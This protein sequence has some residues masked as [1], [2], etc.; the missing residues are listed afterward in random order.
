ML[1]ITSLLLLCLGFNWT[2][3]GQN[4]QIVLT[5]PPSENAQ[6]KGPNDIIEFPEVDSQFKGGPKGLQSYISKNVHYPD[7]AV[8]ENITGKVYLSFV[9][10][11]NGK[12]SNVVVERSAHPSLDQEALRLI[13]G[14]PKWKPAK[15]NGKKVRSRARLP[16][17]FTLN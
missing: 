11:M 5:P 12:I 2:V 1:K 4:P 16:I 3:Y 13:I 17:N 15:Q 10:E 7:D 14:M 8:E 6:P 9:V